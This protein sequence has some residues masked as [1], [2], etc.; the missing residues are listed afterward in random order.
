VCD[1]KSP[2]IGSRSVSLA[3]VVTGYFDGMKMEWAPLRIA[4]HRIAVTADGS[5]VSVPASVKASVMTEK[6]GRSPL[7]KVASIR[8]CRVTTRLKFAGRLRPTS[9]AMLA[10]I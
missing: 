5:A 10:P 8:L 7:L 6:A 1:I 4:T 9:E 3:R 2:S